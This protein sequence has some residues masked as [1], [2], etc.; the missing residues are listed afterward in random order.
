MTAMTAMTDDPL[1]GAAVAC[2]LMKLAGERAAEKAAGPGSFAVL[3]LDEI[4]ALTPADL[5]Q[6]WPA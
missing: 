4:A 1:N 2:A 5:A 3:L 6:R